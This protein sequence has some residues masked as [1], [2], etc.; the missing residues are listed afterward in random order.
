MDS[1]PGGPELV[2][3]SHVIHPCHFYVRKYS[4]IKDAVVLKKKMKQI[5][6]KTLRL[7]PSDILELGKDSSRLYSQVCLN[8]VIF[9]QPT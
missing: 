3:V 4:Q 1:C 6:K 5:C 8:N 7:D 9:G 2:F